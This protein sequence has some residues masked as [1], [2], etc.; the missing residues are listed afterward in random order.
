MARK[1]L[2]LLHTLGAVGLSG[3]LLVHIILLASLTDAASLAEQMVVRSVIAR[4]AEWLLLP[5]LG[6][7]LA[8]GLL[9]LAA[10]PPFRNA[11]WVW[12]KAALGLAVFEGT[13]VSVQGPAVRNA[14]YTARALAGEL[15][16]ARLAA[17]LHSEWGAL[18]LILAVAMANII[19]GVWRPN[20]RRR[21]GRDAASDS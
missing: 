20:L 13:L 12:L 14:E 16:P 10:H 2:K 8:A 11:G 6:I 18:W 9:S 17:L 7:V 19:I 4:V 3:A 5:S 1:T 21:K 15:E